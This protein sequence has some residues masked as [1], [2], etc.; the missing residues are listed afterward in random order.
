MKYTQ[1]PNGPT[2]R[3]DER[4][5]WLRELLDDAARCGRLSAWEENFVHDVAL[6]LAEWGGDLR[7]SAKQIEVL[8]RIEK[9]V[10]AL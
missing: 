7:L 3:G 8:E 10:H 1:L 5:A 2:I 6:R 4:E 9:K